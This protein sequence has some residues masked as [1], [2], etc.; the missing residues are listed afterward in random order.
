M[1]DMS[2]SKHKKSPNKMWVKGQVIV[3]KKDQEI[4][5]NAI[6]DPGKP[7]EALWAAAEEYKKLANE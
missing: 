3:S 7:N 1:I 6:M 2:T 4:F 5:F